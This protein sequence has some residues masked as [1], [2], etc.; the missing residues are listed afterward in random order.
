MTATRVAPYLLFGLAAAA[1]AA[2]WRWALGWPVVELAVV[3]L[4]AIVA[5]QEARY[6]SLNSRFEEHLAD[7][8][9]RLG[10]IAPEHDDETPWRDG[11]G[12]DEDTLAAL[13]EAAAEVRAIDGPRPSPRPRTEPTESFEDWLARVEAEHKQDMARISGDTEETT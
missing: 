12:L 2:V 3:I 9:E 7:C 1:V 10:P 5:L 8:D 11:A 13:D 4:A 6:L